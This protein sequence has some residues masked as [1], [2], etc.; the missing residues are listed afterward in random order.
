MK[1]TK[2]TEEIS[3]KTQEIIGSLFNTINYSSNEQLN[4]FIDGMNEEQ[5]MY[6]LKEALIACH[7]RGAFTM[8][9]TEAVSKSL[10]LLKF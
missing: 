9:E 6:C 3:K 10:R 4:L 8:E 5:A 2:N 7:V 1:N